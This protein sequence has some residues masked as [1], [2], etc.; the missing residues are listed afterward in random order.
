MEAMFYNKNMTS[1]APLLF[2]FFSKVGKVFFPDDVFK[3]VCHLGVVRKSPRVGQLP[4]F[5]DGKQCALATNSLAVLTINHE[6]DLATFLPV[7][8]DPG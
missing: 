8:L 5:V 2:F 6:M 1:M 7:A 4:R 3:F